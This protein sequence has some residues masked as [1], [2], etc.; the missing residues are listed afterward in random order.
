MHRTGFLH[1][2]DMFISPGEMC[3]QA[4]KLNPIQEAEKITRWW[5]LQSRNTLIFNIRPSQQL[6]WGGGLLSPLPFLGVTDL[7]HHTHTHTHTARRSSHIIACEWDTVVLLLLAPPADAPAL[8]VPPRSG[9]RY[10][11][12]AFRAPQAQ[13]ALAPVGGDLEGSRC[14]L[15]VEVRSWSDLWQNI[16]CRP[17]AGGGVGAGAGVDVALRHSSPLL[18]SLCRRCANV[19]V[20]SL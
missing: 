5:S 12:N 4:A 2:S 10:S 15:R 9:S 6:R 7:R 13:L 8:P 11:P 20:P 3:W 16:K 1:C 17:G 19:H 14:D 18:V